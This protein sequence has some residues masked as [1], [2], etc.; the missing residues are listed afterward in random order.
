MKIGEEAA[1]SRMSGK[2]IPTKLRVLAWK[3][4]FFSSSGQSNRFTQ[5][6][7]RIH[8]W[9]SSQTRTF[10]VLSGYLG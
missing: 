5:T 10:H 9:S 2:T 6:T 3:A 1:G 8:G 7:P 4:D